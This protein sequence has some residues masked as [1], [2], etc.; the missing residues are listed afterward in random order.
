VGTVPWNWK[1]LGSS[2]LFE[3][4]HLAPTMDIRA[5]PMGALAAHLGLGD[6]ALARVFPGSAGAAPLGGMTRAG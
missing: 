5:V 3:N 2:Q 6:A 1:G 4:R